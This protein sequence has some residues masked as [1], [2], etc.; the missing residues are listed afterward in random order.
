MDYDPNVQELPPVKAATHTG[1]TLVSEYFS[2]DCF[3]PPNVFALAAD[4]SNYCQATLAGSAVAS[5]HIALLDLQVQL[6]ILQM[7]MTTQEIKRQTLNL[8]LT[9]HGHASMTFH[10]FLP[11]PID[12]LDDVY[13]LISARQKMHGTALDPVQMVTLY[14][15]IHHILK[16][17]EEHSIPAITVNSGLPLHPV[18]TWEEAE[19]ESGHI[20][21]DAQGMTG[22]VD[23]I[24][25]HTFFFTQIGICVSIVYSSQIGATYACKYH[26]TTLHLSYLYCIQSL[27][28]RSVS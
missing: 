26:L 8:Q 25:D 16:N 7:M 21:E 18:A 17:H 27:C 14:G 1:K 12:C 5:S 23:G 11:D 13:N 22:M 19:H 6:H 2:G 9:D 15:V 10:G 28:S 24:E 20:W 3:E 4:A